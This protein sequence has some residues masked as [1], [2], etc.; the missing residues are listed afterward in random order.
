MAVKKLNLMNIV[1]RNVYVDE[2]LRDLILEENCQFINAMTEI[3]E[4]D[5][6]IG[7]TEEHA[8]EILDMEDI[9]ALKENKEI[10][11]YFEKMDKIVK[12][13][14]Y[15]PQVKKEWMLGAHNFESIK[16]EIDELN[17]KFVDL[18]ENTDRVTKKLEHL[19]ALGYL[20]KLRDIDVDFTNLT[21][22]KHFTV[23]FGFLTKEKRKKISQ[24]YEN[25]RAIVL[26][27]G[28]YEEKE[29]Y[30]IISPKSLDL[31]MGR[32]LRSTDFV[33]LEIDQSYLST[34][35]EMEK[36]INKDIIAYK[37]ELE[38]LKKS[39][40]EYIEEYTETIDKL[41]SK[42]IMEEKIN[43]LRPNIASTKNFSYLSAW[44][45]VDNNGN[46][47]DIFSKYKNILVAYKS[48]GEITNKITSPTFLKNLKFFRPFETLV[49]MYGVPSHNETDPTMFFGIAYIF[50]FGAMFGDF[51]Q[52]VI[53]I[54][55]GLVLN[56]TKMKMFGELVW[57][58]GIGTMTFGILYDSFFGY[59]NIISKL[60][61]FNIYL[62]PID[63]IN[64]IL[65]LAILIGIIL[66]VTSYLLSI[67]NKLKRKEMEEAL[68]GR[69]GVNGLVL[70]LSLLGFVYGIATGNKII[71]VQ[72]NYILIGIS[73]ILLVVKQPL[74]N[75]ISKDNPIY[76]ESPGE[77]YT[78]SG[79]NVFE[80][81]L[82]LLSNSISF[83]RVGAFALNHVGL[84]IAFH[85]MADMIGSTFGN[86][87]MFIVGNVVIIGLEGLIVF[88]QGL[89]LFYYEI[90]SKYYIGEGVLFNPDKI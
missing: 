50:L 30:I 21:D 13:L 80:T 22:L 48:S 85:T 2:L 90:F 72:I 88:I 15:K 65:I 9:V 86:V 82:S 27:I 1:A 45:P 87:L 26:H 23:K 10:Q 4:S 61:P 34:P 33:E 35:I 56:K 38:L 14:N 52:G 47:K 44:V 17:V 49:N 54:I 63:N 67:F 73:I 66:L 29:L 57:R 64:T 83:I 36:R 59:E 68:F 20:D 70:F 41:Y 37:E 31:E 40:A 12:G 5:F 32:I 74:Y 79:F 81:L 69:N 16:M 24:N 7:M 8:D 43:S 19:N 3:E 76:D 28:S 46:Y 55:A 58:I 51:G 25:I 77:Y 60:L 84:F 18:T 75:M 53:F 39:A 89:R 62:R 71:P 42:M 6:A 11:N 78:E